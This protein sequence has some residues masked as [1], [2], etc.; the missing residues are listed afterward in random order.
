MR[1]FA[2]NEIDV[3]AVL[4]AIASI[5]WSRTADGATTHKVHHVDPSAG[6]VTFA[7][8]LSMPVDT[9]SCLDAI[10]DYCNT[11]VEP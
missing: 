9:Y 4:E 3:P 10:R 2:G 11:E 1:D 5:D 8:Y 7:D 6:I